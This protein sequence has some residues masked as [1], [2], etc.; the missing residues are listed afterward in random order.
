MCRNRKTTL[1]RIQ[2]YQKKGVSCDQTVRLVLSSDKGIM[3]QRIRVG[4][5]HR[6]RTQID[7]MFIPRDHSSTS[8]WRGPGLSRELIPIRLGRPF[9]TSPPFPLIK[10]M[11]CN[12]TDHFPR[13]WFEIGDSL[14]GRC[15]DLGGTLSRWACVV[16]GWL[17]WLIRE[18]RR[19]S[20]FCCRR[21]CDGR[22]G[23]RLRVNCRRLVERGRHGGRRCDRTSDSG[24]IRD[25]SHPH[26]RD[27]GRKEKPGR[28]I[29]TAFVR[30]VRRL[31]LFSGAFLG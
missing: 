30:F 18:W 2:F 7:R 27:D 19:C 16:G 1:R 15:I 6:R 14:C 4:E 13:R 12:P 8:Q 31:V 21:L 3:S 17:L 23:F 25:R 9:L 22:P 29:Q 5:K 24:S 10:H 28:Y 20:A 11:G 26:T